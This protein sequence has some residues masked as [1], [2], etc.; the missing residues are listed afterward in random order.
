MNIK[1]VPIISSTSCFNVLLQELQLCPLISSHPPPY[2]HTHIHTQSYSQLTLLVLQIDLETQSSLSPLRGLQWLFP[3]FSVLPLWDLW[4]DLYKARAPT[5]TH[6][7]ELL[8]LMV[9]DAPDYR[10]PSEGSPPT[11]AIR[12]QCTLFTVL[13]FSGWVTVSLLTGLPPS[14]SP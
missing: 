1:P 11:A 5:S 3:F 8:Q 4:L 12:E 13:S 9:P 7:A 10:C 14:S 6:T 2:T